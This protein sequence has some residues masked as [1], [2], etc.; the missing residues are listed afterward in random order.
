MNNRVGSDDSGTE[1]PMLKCWILAE[2]AVIGWATLQ[3]R[4][5]SMGVIGGVFHPLPAYA[6]VRAQIQATSMDNKS[7]QMP[8]IA[9]TE[10]GGIL[11]ARSAMRVQYGAEVLW[12][13]SCRRSARLKRMI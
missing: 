6:T 2:T 11:L 10:A 1:S 12:L 4:D 8:L 13:R 9:R 3:I 5:R 7:D